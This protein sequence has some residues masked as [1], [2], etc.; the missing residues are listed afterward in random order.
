[1]S[2][3]GLEIKSSGSLEELKITPK[4]GSLSSRD[5]ANYQLLFL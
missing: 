5:F 1:M 2:G 3:E 4:M